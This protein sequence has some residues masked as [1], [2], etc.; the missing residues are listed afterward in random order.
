MHISLSLYIYIYINIYYIYMHNKFSINY[1]YALY[2][3]LLC[4]HKTQHFQCWKSPRSLFWARIE[5]RARPPNILYFWYIGNLYRGNILRREQPSGKVLGLGS[6]RYPVRFPARA[7]HFW[8]TFWSGRGHFFVNF[9]MSW[10]VS[11]SGQG[12]FLDGFGMVFEKMSE[13]VQKSKF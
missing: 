8:V 1:L 5:P 7:S 13:G 11:G 10:D 2:S 6:G 3:F 4:K 9:G 12:M